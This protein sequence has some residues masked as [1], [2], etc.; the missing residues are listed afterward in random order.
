MDGLPVP[1]GDDKAA[2]TSPHNGPKHIS[3]GKQSFSRAFPGPW[4]AEGN[5]LSLRL[6]KYAVLTVLPIIMLA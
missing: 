6:L 3:K 1:D 2:L 4:D 5:P